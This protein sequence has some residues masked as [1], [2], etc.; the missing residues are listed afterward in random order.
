[1]IDV[2]THPSSLLV[3]LQFAALAAVVIRVIMQR[4]GP[5]VALAWL[6]LV[7]ILPLVGALLYFLIGERRIHGDRLARMDELR[8]EYAA[9]TEA[10]RTSGMHDVDW[11][12]HPPAARRLDRIGGRMTN[13]FAVTGSDLVLYDDTQEIL[14]AIAADVDAAQTSILMEFYIWNEGGSADNVLEAVKR[15]AAR[16]V[17][18]RLLIDALGARPWWRSDQIEDLRSAGVQVLQARPVGTFRK[19]VGRTDL[20]LHRK[21]VVV[22]GRVAWT[23]SM[24]MV[25]PGFFKQDAGVG[26]WVDAMVRVQGF[27]VAQLA[28]VMLGDWLLESPES[29]SE[30][31]ADAGLH[32]LTGV[33]DTDLQV[34]SS[35]PGESDDALLLMLNALIHGA[36]ETLTLTTPYLVPDESLL[37]ALRAASL[38]GVRITLILPAAV[39]SVMTRYASRSYY[40]DLMDAGVDVWLYNGGLLHTKSIL[41]DDRMAMFGTVNLDMRSLWLNHEVALFVYGPEFGSDLKAL[42]DSY[43]A[44]A[45]RL[46]PNTWLR[47]PGWEKFKENA[48]RIAS[49]LL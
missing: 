46:D 49:P 29:L 12:R 25:D 40:D 8:A 43:L 33:G 4:P 39:D 17:T 11:S 1:M 41:A 48:F 20:R 37:R 23:G 10:M 36:E 47:R 32:G 2:I 26:E 27:A 24:N 44:D 35:G 19:F 22:D 31:V 5:G 45:T 6:L 30:T 14:A 21:I 3:V 13:L 16:G 28:A 38:R 18:C 34:L 9:L 42:H 15:A 7:A